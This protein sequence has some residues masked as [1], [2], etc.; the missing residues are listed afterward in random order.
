MSGVLYSHTAANSI[1][2]GAKAYIPLIHQSQ[3]EKWVLSSKELRSLIVSALIFLTIFAWVDV[4]ATMYKNHLLNKQEEHLAGFPPP[5]FPH[6]VPENLQ[7]NTQKF[8]MKNKVG[9]AIILTGITMAVFV[10]LSIF[11]KDSEFRKNNV[12][13]TC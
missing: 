10:T 8:D 9:Y 5:R 6:H 1:L 4:V 13:L 3:K 2:H 7:A 11:F 12:P